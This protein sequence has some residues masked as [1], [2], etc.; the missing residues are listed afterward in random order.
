MA[1][2]QDAAPD[3][4]YQALTPDH[5]LYDLVYNPPVTRFLQR[6]LDRNARVKNGLEMLQIQAEESWKLWQDSMAGFSY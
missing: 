5:L 1:P 3:I 4:P 2:L 6:G